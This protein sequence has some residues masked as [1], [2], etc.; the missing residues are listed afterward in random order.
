MSYQVGMDPK[1]MVKKSTSHPPTLRSLEAKFLQPSL[2]PCSLARVR[3]DAS[4]CADLVSNAD[5]CQSI[6]QN[7]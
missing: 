5:R 2:N 1:K 4:T 3:R 6:F 7:R